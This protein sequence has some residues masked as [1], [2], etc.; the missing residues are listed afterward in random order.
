M[1][2]AAPNALT[3]EQVVKILTA[4]LEQAAKFLA[5]GPRIHDTDGSPVR[6]PLM[7]PSTAADLTF[8]DQNE[9]IPEN[10]PDLTGEVN[11]L[12]STMKSIK[13]ITR[14]SNEL[15]RQSIVS[16]DSALKTRL[17]AD[18]ALKLDATL[19]GAGGDGVTTPQGMFGWTGTQEIAAAAAP[20]DLDALMDAYGLALAANVN[21]DS[22]ALFITPAQYMVLRK[23]KDDAGRYLVEPDVQNGKLLVPMLGA[24]A[25]VSSHVPADSFALADMSHVAVA[26][27]MAP[28]VTV[29][30]ER[31]ADYDQQA[32][33]VVARYDAKPTAPEA[34]VK[35]TGLAVPA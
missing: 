8:V 35:V 2:N 19:L 21:P 26:R 10:D 33:R 14:Y 1:A 23:L 13:T 27:D 9:L 18:V 6:L 4:P 22:M 29:L 11:L 28:S 12:P 30:T 17:V 15:A 16:L 3:A 25:Q 34:I 20:I 31:Y 7:P 5:A 32:I 24:T